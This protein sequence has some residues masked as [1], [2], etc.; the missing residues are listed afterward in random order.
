MGP[1]QGI[2]R[3]TRAYDEI[4]EQLGERDPDVHAGTMFGMPTFLRDRKAFGGLTHGDMVFKLSGARHA[5]ALALAGAHLFDP[6]DMGRPMKQWVVVPAAHRT[7]WPA[8][9]QAAL[10]DLRRS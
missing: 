10:D 1:A 6:G 7:V 2:D 4:V 3:S 9:A 5:E 8:L